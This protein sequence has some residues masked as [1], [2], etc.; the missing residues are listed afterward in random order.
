M[1]L[2]LFIGDSYHHKFLAQRIMEEFKVVK[3]I[4]DQKKL[5]KNPGVL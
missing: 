2:I 1:N 3:I 4:I 5:L